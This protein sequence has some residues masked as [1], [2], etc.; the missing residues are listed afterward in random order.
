M[1]TSCIKETGIE[2]PEPVTCG[3]DEEY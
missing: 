1:Y 3:S 2:T